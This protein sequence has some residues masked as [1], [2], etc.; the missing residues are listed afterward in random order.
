MNSI[1]VRF[2]KSVDAPELLSI[3]APYVTSTPVTFE[4]EVPSVAEFEKRIEAVTAK[5]PWLVC[6]V[7]G[8][9]AG[10][11]YASTY[12]TRAAFQWD[13]EVS[14]YLTEPF[15]RFGIASAL[16]KCLFELLTQQNYCNLYALITVPN[17]ASIG[18]HQSC[19][20]RTVG[21]MPHTGYKFDSWHDMSVLEK[22]LHDFK[23]PFTPKPVKSIHELDTDFVAKALKQCEDGLG[24]KLLENSE[25]D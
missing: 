24:K 19:G 14:V 1:S 11:V 4:Y 25:I 21:T 22:P 13:A 5:F 2:A 9:I 6:E 16:Y 12:R 18:F 15:H 20:F 7:D 8:K 3:Y 10:Y 17:E 23:A